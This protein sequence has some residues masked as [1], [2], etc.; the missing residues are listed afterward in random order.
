VELTAKSFIL[1]LLSTLGRGTM[2]VAALVEAAGL[3]GIAE[4][5]LRVALTRLTSTGLVE[6]DRRGRYRMG[7]GAE[8]VARRVGSWRELERGLR[9]W[10]ASWVGVLAGPRSSGNQARS[11]RGRRERALRLLGL[12]SLTPELALRPD[13]LP[14]G[15][16]AVRGELADLGLPPGHLVFC[17][18]DLDPVTDVRARA[19]WEGDALRAA[20]RALRSRVEDGLARLGGQSTE[21]A[22]VESFRLGGQ[23]IRQLIL[24]PRVPDE[25]VPGD[26]RR[27]LVETMR[28]YDVLGRRAWAAFLERFAVPHLQAPVDTRMVASAE[29]LSR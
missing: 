27:A 1:D 10:D 19:C 15:V 18:R 24:D 20:H 26:E 2:P 6:R 5:S 21:Q 28:R 3:F 14:G 8:A 7:R 4:N 29:R 22:M 16:A 17:L 11:R 25:I 12:R 13:N 23:V 9:A